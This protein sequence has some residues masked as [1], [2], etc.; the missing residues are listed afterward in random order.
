MRKHYRVV[1]F[2]KVKTLVTNDTEVSLHNKEE[3]SEVWY[4]HFC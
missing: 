4:L 2:H 1:S 3:N